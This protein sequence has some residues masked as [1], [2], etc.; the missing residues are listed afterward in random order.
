[1][2]ENYEPLPHQVIGYL[3]GRIRIVR[4]D[5]RRIGDGRV[6]PITS[7]LHIAYEE[8]IAAHCGPLR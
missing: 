8:L 4:I 1:M 6:G 5:G 2:A 7:R 3:I